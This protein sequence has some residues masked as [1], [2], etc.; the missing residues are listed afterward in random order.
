MLSSLSTEDLIPTD[1]PIR[2]IRAVVDDVLGG[3][4]GE[5]ESMYA[6]SGR[7]SV[8]PRATVE[9]NGVDGDVLDAFR[10]GRSANASTTTCCSSGS[11]TWPSMV[12]PLTPRRSRRTANDSWSM[13]SRIGSSL[14]GSLR[15]SCA[16]TCRQITSRSMGRCCRRGRRTRASNQTDPTVKLTTATATGSRGRNAEVDFKGQKRSNK[17]HT[18]DH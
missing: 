9:G 10:A 7:R 16:A 15:R 1:H 14:R 13:R 11:S 12:G 8:P 6:T 2:R 17:T 4:D 3:L 5:F 18:L